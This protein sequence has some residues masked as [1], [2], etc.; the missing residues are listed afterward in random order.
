M[1]FG[2][3][4]RVDNLSLI[5]WLAQHVS[6]FNPIAST[7]SFVLHEVQYINII[8]IGGAPIQDNGSTTRMLSCLL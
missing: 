3:G 2:L 8:A 1:R 6:N 5:S 4:H 7:V